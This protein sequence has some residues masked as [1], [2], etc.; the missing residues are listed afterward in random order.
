MPGDRRHEKNAFFPLSSSRKTHDTS[1]YKT[2]PSAQAN[3]KTASLEDPEPS[4]A[5]MLVLFSHN[6][7]RQKLES[8]FARFRVCRR[9]SQC[10]WTSPFRAAGAGEARN[11][12]TEPPHATAIAVA[13]AMQ[14]ETAR[15]HL[16]LRF[17]PRRTGRRGAMTKTK[18][19]RR[20]MRRR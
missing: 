15:A 8:Q 9:V 12:T 20:L 6:F 3:A 19:D 10:R 4:S 13:V 17:A 2:H 5:L 1:S 14:R 16:S 18:A 7:R 11:E